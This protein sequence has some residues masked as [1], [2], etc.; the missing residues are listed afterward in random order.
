MGVWEGTW[1][2]VQ[3]ADND[4]DILRVGACGSVRQVLEGNLGAVTG[5]LRMML[6]DFLK[7]CLKD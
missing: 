6:D 4:E 5:L 2:I 1:T 3:A 7:I